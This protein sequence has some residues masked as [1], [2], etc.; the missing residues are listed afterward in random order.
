MI[1]SAIKHPIQAVL[2]KIRQLA[3][4]PRPQTRFS[5]TI[6]AKCNYDCPHC[7]IPPKWRK[8]TPEVP[9]RVDQCLKA[10][11]RIFDQKGECFIEISGGEPT[12]YPGF[13]D[14]LTGI[15]PLHRVGISTNLSFNSDQFIARLD[16]Q[17]I[18]IYPSFHPSH[19]RAEPFLRRLDLL[20]QARFQ[21]AD[22]V[23]VAYPPELP[24]L[25][26]YRRQFREAGRRLELL[27]FRG[28]FRGRDYPAAYSDEEKKLLK[29]A[30]EE[31]KDDAD[32]EACHRRERVD[33]QLDQ[34][35]PRGRQCRAGFLYAR[36]QAEGSVFRCAP[37]VEL[38]QEQR[39]GF[40]YDEDFRMLDGA[41]PCICDTCPCPNEW[42][43]LFT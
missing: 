35:S 12:T 17:R 15:T 28:V 4:E 37:E 5:W 18:Q 6:T 33:F 20:I 27:P 19:A 36:I 11:Q 34:K 9:F 32:H 39:I 22:P 26:E 7:C 10:W 14:I 2:Q 42:T 40:F 43:L 30:I 21:C 13:M 1:R 29:I 25:N 41:A 3:G 8:D 16:S 23:I 38:G 24:R 31:K